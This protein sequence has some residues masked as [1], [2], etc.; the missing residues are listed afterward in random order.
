MAFRQFKLRGVPAIILYEN[1]RAKLI[2][3]TSKNSFG[4]AF[5]NGKKIIPI[6]NSVEEAETNRLL[7]EVKTLDVHSKIVMFSKYY[8]MYTKTIAIDGK[9]IVYK[10]TLGEKKLIAQVEMT[11]ELLKAYFSSDE[12]WCKQK[13]VKNYVANV[14]N[15]RL[16]VKTPQKETTR[17]FPKEWNRAYEGKLTSTE[18]PLYW[19]HLRDLGFVPVKFNG[20][21][22]K[23][24]KSS[25]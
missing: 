21:T 9:G 3:N 7:I 5:K 25:S 2:V 16:L 13:N 18:L 1:G 10:I 12:W 8:K 15:I 22:T 6:P 14:N 24:I 11:E 4:L 23:W 20:K 17:R 19:K